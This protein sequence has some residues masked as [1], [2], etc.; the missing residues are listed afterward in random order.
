M[1]TT[2][3]TSYEYLYID[4]RHSKENETSSQMKISLT[5]P[6]HHAKSVSVC[7]FNTANEFFN[8]K[9]PY[10]TITIG[11]LSDTSDDPTHHIYSIPPGL[12]DIPSIIEKL[13]E[14]TNANQPDLVWCTFAQNPQGRTTLSVQS[15]SNPQKRV[16]IYFPDEP[17]DFYQSLRSRLGFGYDQVAY[18]KDV[19]LKIPVDTVEG[20]EEDITI[21]IGLNFFWPDAD[22]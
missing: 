1:T 5:H 2:S 10:N 14:L 19:N 21:P 22:L 6:I 20:G 12:Y 9:A 15:N 8:I 16:Y 11:V 13:N 4:S 7:S 17:S 3:T 18:V